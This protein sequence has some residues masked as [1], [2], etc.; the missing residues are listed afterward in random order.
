MSPYVVRIARTLCYML[1]LVHMNACA[2]YAFSWQEGLG[3]NGWTYS[4]EGNAY[5]RCFYFA[6]KTAT[7][8]GK[9]PRPESEAEY[10]F[11]TASWL[12]GVFVFALLIGQVRHFILARQLEK[13]T[14]LSMNRKLLDLSFS[15]YSTI[16]ESTNC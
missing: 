15:G 7:S 2:Y 16:A 12:L 8:V 1:Y 9:N 5:I 13:I 14:F 3:S 11:M 4:G 6:T 10:L